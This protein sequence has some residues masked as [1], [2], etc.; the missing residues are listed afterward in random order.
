MVRRRRRSVPRS[1]VRDFRKIIVWQ[2]AHALA[3]SLTGVVE[4]SRFRVRPGWRSQ[5]LR[6]VDAIG[7]LIAEG[8]GK[9][10]EAE[11]GRYLDMAMATAREAENHL[12]VARDIGCLDAPVANRVLD[13]LDEVKRV[14]YGYTRA[15]RPQRHRRG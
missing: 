12:L 4:P 13:D 8:A 5:L 9:S 7:A 3:V 14:L 11:F 10:T 6:S 1:G 15:V 2:K